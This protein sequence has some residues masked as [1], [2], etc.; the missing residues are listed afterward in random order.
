MVMAIGKVLAVVIVIV[1]K[2]VTAAAAAVAAAVAAAGAGGGAGAGAGAGAGGGG[3]G[4]EVEVGVGVRVGV[5]VGVGA[6][7]GA[8]GVVVVVV[9]VV[10]IVEAVG[11]G[12][13]GGGMRHSFGRGVFRVFVLGICNSSSSLSSSRIGTAFYTSAVCASS[14][15]FCMCPFPWVVA[16]FAASISL[17]ESFWHAMVLVSFHVSGIST[18]CFPG[19]AS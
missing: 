3:V 9:A 13:G 6:G 12:G 7:A 16:D 17:S 10:V 19:T 4:V 18:L 11:G 14:F 1:A 2:I 8:G 15:F 5:G